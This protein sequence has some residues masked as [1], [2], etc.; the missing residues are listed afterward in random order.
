MLLCDM[1]ARGQGVTASSLL[2]CY[3]G[4]RAETNERDTE[5]TDAMRC[6]CG[7]PCLAAEPRRWQGHATIRRNKGCGEA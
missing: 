3:T 6:M 1:P 4:K 5:N 7:P 2:S